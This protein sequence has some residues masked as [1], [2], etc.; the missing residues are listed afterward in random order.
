MADRMIAEDF[1]LVKQDICPYCDKALTSFNKNKICFNCGHLFSWISHAKWYLA[2]LMDKVQ[3]E[4]L[5]NK[6]GKS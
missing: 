4:K 1:D 6:Y 2:S 5:W 3:F